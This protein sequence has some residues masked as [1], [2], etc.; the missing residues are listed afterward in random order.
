MD[1]E[2][3]K[4]ERCHATTTRRGLNRQCMHTTLR[5]IYCHQHE[6]QLRGLR[7][8]KNDDNDMGVFTTRPIPKGAIICQYTGDVM[9]EDD[10][11]Y[12][13]PFALQ[14]KKRPATFIV[15]NETNEPGEGRWINDSNRPNAEIVINKKDEMAKV[16]ALRDI[17]PDEE[18]LVDFETRPKP[19]PKKMV[20]KL[21][22]PDRPDLPDL[23]GPT[24]ADYEREEREQN[25]LLA[26][27]SRAATLSVKKTKKKAKTPREKHEAEL[28]KQ[29]ATLQDLFSDEKLAAQLKVPLSKHVI[30]VHKEKKLKEGEFDLSLEKLLK[31]EVQLWVNHVNKN[32]RNKMTASRAYDIIDKAS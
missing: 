22:K 30:R 3:I 25:E 23:P 7:I 24:A 10:P 29:L 9:E 5:G 17:S 12:A 1:K 2:I 21:I 8:K 4:K 6:R 26:E 16:R 28:R 27:Q 13:N 11:T 15:A 18:I 19:K 32:P 20:R 31:K 14:I